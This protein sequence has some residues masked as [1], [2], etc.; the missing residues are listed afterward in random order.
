MATRA[1]IAPL[2]A[3]PMSIFLTFRYMTA[4]A[5]MTP[6]AAARFV[7]MAIS[8]KRPS[9]AC[10]PEPGLNPNQPSH[11]IRMPR[12]NSGM[13][14]PGIA[15]G[16]SSGPYFPGCGPWWSTTASGPVLP[17][18]RPEVQQHRQRAV[19]ADQVDRRRPGEVLHAEVALQPAA[20]EHP[21]R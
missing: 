2:P 21:V 8:G 3:M 5:E 14:W 15:R 1:A 18:A 10:R 4:T 6:A 16:L 19:G 9:I 17:A 11:R 20:A 12:P 13:L 7:T